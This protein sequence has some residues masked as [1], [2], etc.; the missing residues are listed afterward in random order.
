[1][2]CAEFE[3]IG[4]LL[5]T[6]RGEKELEAYVKDPKGHPVP[7]ATRL[8][9]RLFSNFVPAAGMHS[10]E[11]ALHFLT[12]MFGNLVCTWHQ[13]HDK[14]FKYYDTTTNVRKGAKYKLYGVPYRGLRTGRKQHPKEG[15][16]HCGC[17][18]DDALMAFFWFKHNKYEST[19]AERKEGW[20]N[21]QL[22]ARSRSLLI[23]TF[24]SYAG[25]D[26]VDDMYEFDR[27]GV[28]RSEKDLLEIQISKLQLQ[29]AAAE[30]DSAAEEK[31]LQRLDEEA[32]AREENIGDWRSEPGPSKPKPKVTVEKK[33]ANKVEA[34]PL[35]WS[36]GKGKARYV[37]ESS[38]VDDVES[39]GGDEESE[40]GGC[41]DEQLSE[42]GDSEESDDQNSE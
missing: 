20:C 38:E 15:Y 32:T 42:D 23:P 34:R 7:F 41:G 36:K 8:L 13:G 17:A 3:V 24:L 16:M 1:M 10:R 21:Q 5:L 37:E 25:F 26:S 11:T 35:D 33:K 22:E 28:R 31:E 27:N 19:T 39:D 40:W 9:A 12:T 6:G 14:S 2:I 30:G 29:L 4:N 18:I